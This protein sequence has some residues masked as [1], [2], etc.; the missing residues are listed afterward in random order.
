MRVLEKKGV[1]K[2]AVF[3]ERG[4]NWAWFG[5][6]ERGFIGDLQGMFQDLC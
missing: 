5:G 2:V 4:L 3:D 6:L 1:L